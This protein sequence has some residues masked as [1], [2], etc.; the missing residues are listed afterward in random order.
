MLSKATRKSEVVF[1]G[2]SHLNVCMP[3]MVIINEPPRWA[4]MM[5]MLQAY[6]PRASSVTVSAENVENV[7]SPPRKPVMM[8]RRHSGDHPGAA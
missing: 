5:T 4:A 2:W 1:Y 7:V 8:S 6:C 3:S